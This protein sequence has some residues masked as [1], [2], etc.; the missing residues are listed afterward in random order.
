MRP[1]VVVTGMG[2]VSPLG[3]DV[4][5]VWGNVCRGESGIRRTTDPEL[6]IFRSKIFG[7]CPDFTT[8]PYIPAHEAK[9][10]DRFVQYALVAAIDAVGQSGL[11]FEKENRERCCAIIGCGVGGLQEIEYQCVKLE[12]KGPNKTSPYTIPKIMPNAA[13]GNVS[14]HFGLLGPSYAVSTACASSTNAM[15]DAI[16]AIR[17]GDA[18]V[19]ITGGTEAAVTRLGICG[20][21][22]MRALSERNEE[23]E[24]ASRPYD[25]GRDG[26]VLSEGA[27]I[28]VF[29]EYEHARKR[30]AVVLGEVLGTGLSSDAFHIAQPE[31][32]GIG[33]SRAIQKTLED[34]GIDAGKVDYINLHGTGT[35]LGDIA[36]VKAVKRAFGESLRGIALSSTKSQI[37]HL[38]GGSGGVEL[39]VTLLAL[40]DGIVPPTSNLEDPDPECDLDFTPLTARERKLTV[41]LSNSFGFGGH[42]ACVLVSR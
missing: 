11:D 12:T 30:G 27:G 4:E 33:A 41:A 31:P 9:K 13:A 29:E 25:K 38:L 32:E 5:Q 10:I 35:S 24:K 28:L 36:E 34:A 16:R 18:D 42:N 2:L 21:C 3:K 6:S 7:V 23:P 14:I 8:D 17:C 20:F 40:R 15:H 22:A 19:V 37:G 1:R 26:F 39:I